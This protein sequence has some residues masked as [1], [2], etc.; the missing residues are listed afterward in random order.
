MAPRWDRRDE[1]GF[2]TPQFVVAV[3]LSLILLVLLANLIVMQ[4]GRGV[5]RAALDEGARRGSRV[6]ADPAGECAARARDVLADL[7][8]GPMGLGVAPIACT[9]TGDR[10]VARTTVT[11]LGWLPG[12]PDWSF[13][14]EASAVKERAP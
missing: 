1:D 10:L 11:F 8:D 9:D 7:L 12:A 4:Y 14:A 13:D 5:V 6:S 2:L 3:G